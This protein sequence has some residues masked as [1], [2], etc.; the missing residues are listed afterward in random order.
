[1]A[2]AASLAPRLAPAPSPTAPEGPTAEL[3]V[4]LL[5]PSARIPSRY[6][7]D[8]LG[9]RLFEL[10]TQLPEYYLTRVE[11]ALL[12]RHAPAVAEAVGAR[13]LIDLGAGNC[14]KSRLLLPVLRPVEYVAVDISTEFVDRALS[15]LR[16]DFPDLRTRCL[17]ADLTADFDAA[18][19]PQ[20]RRLFFFPGSSIGNFDPDAAEALLKRLRRHCRDGDGLLIGIDLVK[21]LATLEAAYNDVLGIT[22]AFN[23]NVLNHV[24]ALLGSD[25]DARAWRHH[26]FYNCAR[27]RMEMHLLAEAP[28]DVAWPGGARRFLV[29]EGIHTENSYKY[30][31]DDFRALLGRA[32][33]GS[34][35]HW[36]DADRWFAVCLA[37][38]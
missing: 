25:F 17:D 14:A 16:L 35:R 22:A 27:S 32:G 7:Y 37:Q 28:I 6:L 15:A 20:P 2:A 34:V 12:G 29:G 3:A 36:T 38:P 33:F 30:R 9:S 13:A 23:R 8:S 1:M 21:E 4:G 24:N 11:C 26:A 19:L 10:I 31:L 5:A 18:D